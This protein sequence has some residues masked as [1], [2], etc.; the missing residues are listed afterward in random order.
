MPLSEHATSPTG[1]IT[2]GLLVWVQIPL[3]DFSDFQRELSKKRFKGYRGFKNYLQREDILKHFLW[4]ESFLIT[5]LTAGQGFWHHC[6]LSAGVL[7]SLHDLQKEDSKFTWL[8]VK[9]VKKIN[10]FKVNILYLNYY[11]RDSPPSPPFLPDQSDLNKYTWSLHKRFHIKCPS[12]QGGHILF[13]E[14]FNSWI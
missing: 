6:R 14:N 13:Q 10:I 5:T 11:V 4:S 8:V 12:I 2:V 1:G 9:I 3:P 7:S